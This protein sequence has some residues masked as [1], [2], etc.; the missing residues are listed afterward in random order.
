MGVRQAEKVAA[1]FIDGT[2]LIRMPFFPGDTAGA[3]R[4]KTQDGVGCLAAGKD[5]IRGGKFLVEKFLRDIFG[6]LGK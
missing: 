2:L 1:V 5:S 3:F 4:G 6:W